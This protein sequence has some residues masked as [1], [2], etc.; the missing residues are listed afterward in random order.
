[1]YYQD[2]RQED[3][4]ASGYNQNFHK[5]VVIL[6]TGNHPTLPQCGK[7]SVVFYRLHARDLTLM[8]M[9]GVDNNLYINT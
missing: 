7:E 4:P 5:L 2:W 9:I 1:M 8:M 3:H 6:T